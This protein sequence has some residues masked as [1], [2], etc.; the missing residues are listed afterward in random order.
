MAEDN[1]G[2]EL[3]RLE[4][5]LDRIAGRGRAGLA[6][7]TADAAHASSSATPPAV[8]SR[9]DALIDQLRGALHL[10]GPATIED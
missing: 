7:T 1:G 3:A 9:L 2:D 4:A 8:A 6:P 10:P 5:A